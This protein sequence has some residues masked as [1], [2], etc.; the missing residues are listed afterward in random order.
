MNK[1]YTLKIADVTEY[2]LSP[3]DIEK[4]CSILMETTRK[5]VQVTT[6]IFTSN[7]TE[8]SICIRYA[9]N[10]RMIRYHHMNMSMYRDPTFE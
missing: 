10:D 9:V 3:K 2:T 7:N 8:I 5:M 1:V 6:I 4:V